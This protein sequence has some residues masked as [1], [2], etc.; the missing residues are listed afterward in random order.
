MEITFVLI[1]VFLVLSR[2][3]GFASAIKALSAG[4]VDSVAALQGRSRV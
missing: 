2:A 1:L 4:Y 3:R